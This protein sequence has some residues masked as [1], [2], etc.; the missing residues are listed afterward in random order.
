M[1]I[2]F[3]NKQYED[4]LKLVYLGNWMANANRADDKL[5]DFD[6][7]ESHIFSHAK[8]YGLDA[9]A[10]S[11]E[12]GVTYP[13]RAFEDSGIQDLIDEYDTDSF[14]EELID[15][16]SARDYVRQSTPEWFATAESEE[17]F[18]KLVACEEVWE[19]EFEAFDIERLAVDESVVV[20]ETKELGE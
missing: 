4:L 20:A 2:N 3:T 5:E 11:D 16:L 12:E 8:E 13:S 17:R 1:N 9:F 7:L 14:W 19:K 15:R 10:D 6:A 18:A